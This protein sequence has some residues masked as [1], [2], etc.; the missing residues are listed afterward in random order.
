M[1]TEA[2]KNK[3]LNSTGSPGP[4]EWGVHNFR[5][6]LAQHWPEYLMEAAGLGIFMVAACVF[7]ALLEYPQSPLHESIENPVA[8][9]VL[10]GLAMGLTAIGVIYSP[11]GQRSGAHINPA[12]TLAFFR[13]GKVK[14]PDAFFYVAAQFFGAVVVLGV[15]FQPR[16]RPPQLEPWRRQPGFDRAVYPNRSQRLRN[17]LGTLCVVSPGWAGDWRRSIC[18]SPGSNT[19]RHA[20]LPALCRFS[21]RFWVRHGERL[22]SGPAGSRYAPCRSGGCQRPLP[23]AA[24]FSPE[25]GFEYDFA[26]GDSD[27]QDGRS[28]EFHNLFPTNHLHYGYGDYMGWRNMQDFKPYFAFLPRANVRAQ[29]SY[30]R[31]LLAEERGAWK[32]AGGKVLGIDPTGLLGT[33]LGHEI[34]LT[35]AFPLYE[36]VRMLAGYSVFLPGEFARGTQG[37]QASQFGYLQTLVTF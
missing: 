15:S 27:P 36:Q 17:G 4:G 25:F 7:G 19:N 33:D 9:R 26:T 22:P 1:N 24:R 13:L 16:G 35:L 10:M 6:A 32:N 29:V 14:L 30:H 3:I 8:R 37:S 2:G 20:R 5:V 34:D 21:K 12:I 11:W 31:L 23:V 18:V 28:G